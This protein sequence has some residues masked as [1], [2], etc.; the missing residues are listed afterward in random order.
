MT[1][2]PP[3]PRQQARLCPLPPTP[4]VALS[5]PNQSPLAKLEVDLASAAVPERQVDESKHGDQQCEGKAG[6]R[7]NGRRADAQERQQRR[8]LQEHPTQPPGEVVRLG[9]ILYG[10]RLGGAA[11]PEDLSA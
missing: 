11:R 4:R 8:H 9:P 6:S 3:G 7:E 10:T 1:D 2:K 5:R